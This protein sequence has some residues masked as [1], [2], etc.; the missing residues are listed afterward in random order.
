MRRTDPKPPAEIPHVPSPPAPSAARPGDG[1]ELARS[2]ARR[3]LPNLV[4]LL[5]S[6]ALSPDSEAPLHTRW[7]CANRLADIA[8]VLPQ[9]VPTMIA[10]V[11]LSPANSVDGG[12]GAQ[13]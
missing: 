10:P 4:R 12:D 9:Q 7:L 8:G 6:L 5:A 3:Y 2:E 11:P 1:L 13:Q